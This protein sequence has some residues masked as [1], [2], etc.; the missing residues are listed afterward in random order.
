MTQRSYLGWQKYWDKEPWG[1]WRDNMHTA[2]IARE[3]RRPQVRRGSRI[4]LDQFLIRDPEERK[5]E[6]VRGFFDFL[7]TVARPVKKEDLLK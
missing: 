7:R 3:L 2:I 4:P 1:P 6:N 5:E